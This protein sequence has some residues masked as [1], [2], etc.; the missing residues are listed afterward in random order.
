MSEQPAPTDHA[1][2]QLEPA[3]ADGGAGFIRRNGQHFDSGLGGVVPSAL[4]RNI[5]G[6]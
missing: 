2:Q 5:H 4:A 6:F 3:A 1:R